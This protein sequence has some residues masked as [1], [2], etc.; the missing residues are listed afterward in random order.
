M[1]RSLVDW[2][3]TF[4]QP[5]YELFR[6]AK[7]GDHVALAT[8]LLQHSHEEIRRA[9]QYK[10]DA[11]RSA[12]HQACR[13]GHVECIHLMLQHPVIHALLPGHTDASGN[14]LLHHACVGGHVETLKFLIRENVSPYQLNYRFQSPLDLARTYYHDEEDARFLKCIEVLEQICTIFEGWIYESTDNL[15][16]NFLGVSALQSWRRRYCVVLRTA[17]TS[18]VELVLY[19][20]DDYS[21]TTDISLWRRPVNPSSIVLARIDDD[22]D[23]NSKQ[24]IFNNKKFAFSLACI[25]KSMT[26]PQ[27][28]AH[29]GGY[30]TLEFACVDADGYAHWGD[31][32]HTFLH[33]PFSSHPSIPSAAPAVAMPK[34]DALK[35]SAPSIESIHFEEVVK[36]SAAPALPSSEC[37]ICLDGPVEAVCVPCGHHAMCMACATQLYNSSRECPVCRAALNQVIRLYR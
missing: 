26:E 18:H 10:D 36:P 29:G 30:K 9:I 11:G 25:K 4:V 32:F 28:N 33:P 20:K 8:Y 15:A 21:A 27:T 19:D 7:R 6:L 14:G 22:I 34:D 16:S 23:F 12:L 35:P 24:K 13:D 5:E 31:F 37:I 2:A 17:L 1:I 3:W